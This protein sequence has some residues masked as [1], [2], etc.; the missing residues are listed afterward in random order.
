MR[1]NVDR[2]RCR[3][4]PPKRAAVAAMVGGEA[5]KGEVTRVD[6][7]GQNPARH[8]ASLRQANR[9]RPAGPRAEREDVVPG[10]QMCG[11]ARE[12]RASG[13]TLPAGYYLRITGTAQMR[14]RPLGE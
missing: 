3:I 9:R 11:L 1:S 4:S 6:A 7:P 8:P 5:G 10:S 2:M 12:R 13:R 14:T